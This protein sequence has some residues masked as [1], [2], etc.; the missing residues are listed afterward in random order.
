MYQKIKSF[1]FKIDPENIHYTIENLLILSQN[2]PMLLEYVAKNLCVI[3][4]RLEQNICG[5][6]FYNPI[7]L[8]A[9]FDKNATMIRSLSA[10]GFGFIEAGTITPMM[11]EGNP[12]PLAH[13][14]GR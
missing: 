7:G 11:Q 14:G 4:S 9:G 13:S 2:T 12:K 8:G 10:I 6:K 1:F 5:I 3:D